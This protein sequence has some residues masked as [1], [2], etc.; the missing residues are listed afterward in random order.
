MSYRNVVMLDEDT[1]PVIAKAFPP[2]YMV[3][4]QSYLDSEYCKE[5]FYDENDNR[6]AT[7]QL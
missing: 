4:H 5:I 1:N 2:K 7:R 6:N 3:Y